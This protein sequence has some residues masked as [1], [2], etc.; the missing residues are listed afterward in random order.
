M[1]TILYTEKEYSTYFLFLFF[2][3]S[4]YAP[5]REWCMHPNEREMILQNEPN[6]FSETLARHRHH[7]VITRR[8]FFFFFTHDL[9]SYK[10]AFFANQNL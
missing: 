4:L 9:G 7:I 10:A 2:F 5:E 6:N 1:F 8:W 3:F